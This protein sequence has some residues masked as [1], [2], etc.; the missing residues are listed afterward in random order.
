MGSTNGRTLS[1]TPAPHND[2]NTVLELRQYGQYDL[3]CL[4]R[5]AF[6]P[7]AHPVDC[8]Q[9]LLAHVERVRRALERRCRHGFG[10]AGGAPAYRAV[11]VPG[12]GAR[13]TGCEAARPAKTPGIPRALRANDKY[14]HRGSRG[15]QLKRLSLE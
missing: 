10:S 9:R 12:S 4:S 1:R 3:L 15:N 5:I 14:S 8:K 11:G 2:L 6:A 7:R 13:S